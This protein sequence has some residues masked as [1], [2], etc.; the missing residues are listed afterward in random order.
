MYYYYST[1]NDVSSVKMRV[2]K[3]IK[4]VPVKLNTGTI[5]KQR[6]GTSTWQDLTPADEQA[7]ALNLL[8]ECAEVPVKYRKKPEASPHKI[9]KL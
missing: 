9:Y 3:M 5:H 7:E 2:Y 6:K 8:I 1:Q 4:K